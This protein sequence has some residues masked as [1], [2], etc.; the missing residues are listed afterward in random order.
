MIAS[1]K[2][3]RIFKKYILLAVALMATSA[4]SC[5][6]DEETEA[7]P[8]LDGSVYFSL[9]KYVRA[10]QKITCRPHGAIHPDGKGIGY[11]WRVPVISEK[12]DTVKKENQDVEPAFAFSAPIDTV[13]S[14][15]V[16]CTAFATGYYSIS[17]SETFTV[18]NPAMGTSL[19]DTGIS[20]DDPHFTDTR[21]S[22]PPNENV[23]FTATA[24]GKTWMRN[25][26]AWTGAGIPLE[27]CMVMSY[28]MGRFYTWEEAMSACPDGWDLPSDQDWA[29]LA[30]EAAGKEY[31]T[32]TTFEGAAGP[33]MV[34]AC[35]NGDPMWEFWP[36]VKKTDKVGFAAIPAGYAT[37]S[38]E[39]ATFSGLNNYAAFWT[40]TEDPSDSGKAVYR[41]INV[42]R[43]DIYV[44]K[45]DKKSF[46]AS[47]RCVKK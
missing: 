32:L 36:E 10:S 40:S 47:V 27:G 31:G 9:P 1:Y 4:I 34:S 6:K 23:Y 37:L 35:F 24:G 20:M 39:R 30:G 25:N 41:Y 3:M 7:L 21:T 15:T 43:N 5:K 44:G 33:L 26:L 12:A 42:N 38:G 18:V 28:P 46:A 19:S 13:G 22:S 17:T 14:F 11:Y 29:A 8:S 45:G 16:T 2:D